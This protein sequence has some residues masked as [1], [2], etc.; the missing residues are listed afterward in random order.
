[1][2]QT[3]LASYAHKTKKLCR[4]Y[5]YVGLWRQG[6]EVAEASKDGLMQRRSVSICETTFIAMHT[7]P[8]SGELQLQ[9]L[10]IHLC[11]SYLHHRSAAGLAQVGGTLALCVSSRRKFRLKGY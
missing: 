11:I 4:L 3:S 7:E 10:G 6:G 9:S 8:S 5:S 1:M 2:M